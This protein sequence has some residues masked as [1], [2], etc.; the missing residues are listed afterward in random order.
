MDNAQNINMMG[1]PQPEFEMNESI[2]HV[3]KMFYDKSKCIMTICNYW[4]IFEHQYE[5]LSSKP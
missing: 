4:S 3:N 1:N 2:Y 5:R